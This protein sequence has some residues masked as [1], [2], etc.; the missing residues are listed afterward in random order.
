[1]F[2]ESAQ[3]KCVCRH[4]SNLG[5]IDQASRQRIRPCGR[6]QQRF[7]KLMLVRRRCYG[8]ACNRAAS[9]GNVHARET[10]NE[11][12][13]YLHHRTEHKQDRPSDHVWWHKLIAPAIGRSGVNFQVMANASTAVKRKIISTH[14][15]CARQELLETMPCLEVHGTMTVQT[16][17]VPRRTRRYR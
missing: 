15:I 4:I 7:Q 14:R 2:R 9:L 13:N 6:E 10:L 12:Q 8:R 3:K 16:Q 17:P 1:M 5:A 11:R